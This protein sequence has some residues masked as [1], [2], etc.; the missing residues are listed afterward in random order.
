MDLGG[1]LEHLKRFSQLDESL[2]S[3]LKKIYELLNDVEIESSTL[4][5]H[6]E[7]AIIILIPLCC[8]NNQ[9]A[10][11]NV[12]QK[13]IIIDTERLSDRLNAEKILDNIL[14]VLLKIS[15]KS[16]L[17][18]VLILETLVKHLENHLDCTGILYIFLKLLYSSE[19]ARLVGKDMDLASILLGQLEIKLLQPESPATHSII[20][21]IHDRK[22]SEMLPLSSSPVPPE[23]S[24]IISKSIMMENESFIGE[25]PMLHGYTVS[26]RELRRNAAK[27]KMED[28]RP[29]SPVV[30]VLAIPQESTRSNKKWDMQKSV[31]YRSGRVS[32]LS[33]SWGDNI[34]SP[35]SPY[36][37]ETTKPSQAVFD[38]D[39]SFVAEEGTNYCE[40][41]PASRV[42]KDFALQ[43]GEACLT[44]DLTALIAQKRD[45]DLEKK[46]KQTA[47]PGPAIAKPRTKSKVKKP[48]KK[49]ARS[50]SLNNLNSPL[51]SIQD[52]YCGE[53][54]DKDSKIT[55]F[56]LNIVYKFFEQYEPYE[57]QFVRN[58]GNLLFGHLLS[59]KFQKNL[60]VITLKS[61]EKFECSDDEQELYEEELCCRGESLDEV[62]NKDW[63]NLLMKKEEAQVL[64]SGTVAGHSPRGAGASDRESR[65]SWDLDQEVSEL[66]LAFYKVKN[67]RLEDFLT[68]A[69]L[70][71]FKI[72]Q[73]F[74]QY[75]ESIH[76]QAVTPIFN[77]CLPSSSSSQL[78]EVLSPKK[79]K[80]RSPNISISLVNEELKEGALWI[81]GTFYKE[82]I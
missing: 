25:L 42:M 69:H 21:Q 41:L 40:V 65:G 70:T 68:P 77:P 34:F 2:N 35:M 8:D 15:Y 58:P 49:N 54:T 81:N 17:A 37:K 47:F 73:L 4:S 22:Q 33:G 12:R 18:M 32:A 71:I 24:R 6:L 80:M 82:M 39:S 66:G 43:L 27:R 60:N 74:S 9:R 63:E 67:S 51:D 28:S 14:V 7:Q 31:S 53:E 26:S 50:S 64:P 79:G 75:T 76:R 46:A 52:F 1:S 59:S 19:Q 62:V 23:L 16:E 45:S 10:S 30:P 72:L 78:Y 44:A 56:L 61:Q 38:F 57:L 20:P 5:I 55:I 29:R 48:L 13:R 36:S 11:R 3:L